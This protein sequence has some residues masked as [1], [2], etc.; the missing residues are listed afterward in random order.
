MIQG[1]HLILPMVLD[2]ESAFE[3]AIQYVI[4]DPRKDNK[5]R[6]VWSSATPFSGITKNAWVTSH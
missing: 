3:N 4:Q 5:K 1:D 2:S 6:Q